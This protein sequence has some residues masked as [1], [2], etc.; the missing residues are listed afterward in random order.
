MGGAAGPVMVDLFTQG[1][2]I[3][4]E[5][6]SG[7]PVGARLI[8]AWGYDDVL[9]LVFEHPSWEVLDDGAEPPLMDIAL[10]ALPP[11]RGLL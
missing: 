2:T 9:H 11:G 5:V 6:V 4:A 3:L 1:N 8:W 7:L 10:R